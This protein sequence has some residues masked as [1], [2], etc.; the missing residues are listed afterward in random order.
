MTWSPPHQWRNS[1]DHLLILELLED[2]VWK[3]DD[4]EG[5]NPLEI[6]KDLSDTENKEGVLEIPINVSDQK[7]LDIRRIRVKIQGN[8]QIS[9]FSEVVPVNV[10]DAKYEKD[11]FGKISNLLHDGKGESVDIKDLFA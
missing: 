7:Y 1:D 11:F 4:E 3:F 10:L 8:Y 9:N 5:E 6:R 2:E